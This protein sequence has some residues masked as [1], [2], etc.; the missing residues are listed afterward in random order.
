MRFD[1]RYL[2]TSR[3]A[4]LTYRQ[5]ENPVVHWQAL[6]ILTSQMVVNRSPLIYGQ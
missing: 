1:L 6:Q 3:Q 4:P 2:A 5:T